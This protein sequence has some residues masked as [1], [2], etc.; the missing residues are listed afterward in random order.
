MYDI[1]LGKFVQKIKTIIT[2]GTVLPQEVIIKNINMNKISRSVCG[3][4][5]AAK[6]YYDESCVVDKALRD[7]FLNMNA[8]PP[9]GHHLLC[10]I[11]LYSTMVMMRDVVVKSYSAN[12][13]F[14]EGLLSIISAF[15]VSYILTNESEK[16]SLTDIFTYC[17][18]NIDDTVDFPL[19][20]YSCK[21]PGSPDFRHFIWPCNIS[22]DA[23]GA[24]FMLGNDI[25]HN[26]IAT[27]NI[28]I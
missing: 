15:P 26:I 2:S 8:L 5:L 10:W 16:C 14:P 21:Y 19:D 4:L 1:E 7:F 6:N 20:L 3:H 22:D 28:E 27:R 17:S 13:K 9:I 18:N 11:Y 12:I 24:A 23:D 25:N